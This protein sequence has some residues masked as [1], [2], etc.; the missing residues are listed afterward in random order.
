MDRAKQLLRNLGARL[1]R[2]TKHLVYELPNGKTVVLS[3]TPSDSYH[4]EQNK[5]RDIRHAAGLVAS[6][7]PE[8]RLKSD[9]RAKPGRH[10]SRDWS[11]RASL[12]T[13]SPLLAELQAQEKLRKA[14]H[15][16]AT[17]R[18]TVFMREARLAELEAWWPVRLRM[19]LARRRQSVMS[20]MNLRARHS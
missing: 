3:S 11:L 2:H 18:R 12:A 5:I 20:W 8:R 9:R 19:W 14:E 15:E 17:L 16:I 6:S 10:D 13:T 4:G 1:K 7:E